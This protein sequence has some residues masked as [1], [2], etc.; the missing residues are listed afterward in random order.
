M[1]AS[2]LSIF[3][4][5][6]NLGFTTAGFLCLYNILNIQPLKN[7]KR[8]EIFRNSCNR[9]KRHRAGNSQLDLGF[10]DQHLSIIVVTRVNRQHFYPQQRSSQDTTPTQSTVTKGLK[11]ACFW[12]NKTLCTE[13]FTRNTLWPK[14]KPQ[15]RW[16]RSK[17]PWFTAFR[18]DYLPTASSCNI[19]R[20][21][22]KQTKN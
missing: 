12:G 13:A 9:P 20:K 15:L 7:K 19:R 4:L 3:T 21:K 11:C 14:S 16:L 10:L 8:H 17:M 2:F 18:T 22:A 6:T 1:M 5:R